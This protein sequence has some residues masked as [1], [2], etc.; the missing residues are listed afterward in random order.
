MGRETKTTNSTPGA[1][2]SRA[3]ARPCGVDALLRPGFLTDTE[4]TELRA[5]M[6]RAPR[7][8]GSV[9]EAEQPGADTVDRTGRNAV[10]CMVSNDTIG[11]IGEQICRVTPQI[12]R[13]FN[14]QL[15]EYEMPHF[16]AYEPGGFYRPHRDIYPDVELPDPLVRRR[17][18]VVVFLNDSSDKPEHRTT[19]STQQYGGGVLRLSSREGNAFDPRFAWDVPAERGLLVAFRA[20]TWHEV[21]PIT[22]GK[23]YTIVAILLAPRR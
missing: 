4:C 20:D 8:E 18:S 21:T 12:A 6:D 17:L 3:A 7:I 13:H 14:Q 23:R 9:R 5:E 19:E 1:G 22:R 10:E 15:A 11:N 2:G 16:V